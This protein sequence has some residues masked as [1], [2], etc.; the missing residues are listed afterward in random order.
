MNITELK[1]K[2]FELILTIENLKKEYE[3]TVKTIEE[4]LIEEQKKQ[5]KQVD[6][7]QI[8]D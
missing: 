6:I 5:Q 2:A 1:A 8:Q 7:E 4:L 3:K